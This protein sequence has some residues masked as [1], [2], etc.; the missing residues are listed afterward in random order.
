M[1]IG[2][3]ILQNNLIFKDFMRPLSEN[4]N[5]F[6]K[7]TDITKDL[8]SKGINDEKPSMFVNGLDQ[9]GSYKYTF[10]AIM[11]PEIVQ[12]ENLKKLRFRFFTEELINLGHDSEDVIHKKEFQVFVL[13]L[14][15][16]YEVDRITTISSDEDQTKIS[17]FPSV[18]KFHF[19]DRP[20]TERQRGK[21]QLLPINSVLSTDSNGRIDRVSSSTLEERNL[22]FI[23]RNI[24]ISNE[25]SSPVSHFPMPTS[26]LSMTQT[27]AGVFDIDAHFS[28]DIGSNHEKRPSTASSV[29]LNQVSFLEI[30]QKNQKNI[31]SRLEDKELID[32]V[33]QLKE[34]NNTFRPLILKTNQVRSVERLITIDFNIPRSV[35]GSGDFGVEITPIYADDENTEK[36]CARSFVNIENSK[37]SESFLSIPIV[38]P[39]I[40]ILANTPSRCILEIVRNDPCDTPIFLYRQSYNPDTNTFSKPSLVNEIQP[41]D[42]HIISDNKVNNYFPGK[43]VYKV[44]QKQSHLSNVTGCTSSVIVPGIKS[45]VL[46]NKQTYNTSTIICENRPESVL[47]RVSNISDNIRKI[48]L[49]RERLSSLGKPTSEKVFIPFRKNLN[50]VFLQ[51]D[52]DSINFRDTTTI[53]GQKYRYYLIMLDE[54]G[55]EFVSNEEEFLER[56]VPSLAKDSFNVSINGPNIENSSAIFEVKVAPTRLGINFLEKSLSEIG[57][58]ELLDRNS[59]SGVLSKD[60]VVFSVDEI[61][62]STGRRKFI[63]FTNA[64]KFTVPLYSDGATRSY[65]FNMCIVAPEA[66][67]PNVDIEI[68]KPGRAGDFKKKYRA[69]KFKSSL[70]TKVGAIPSSRRL[71]SFD[72]GGSI[73]LGKTGLS[74]TRT[75]KGQTNKNVISDIAAFKINDSLAI[76]WRLEKNNRNSVIHEEFMVDYFIVCCRLNGNL[77]T[78]GTVENLKDSGIYY[79]VDKNL[80]REVGNKEYFVIGI[81]NNVK[82]SITSG[83]ATHNRK[84]SIPEELVESSKS[85]LIGIN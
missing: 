81:C 33:L 83:K 65:Q 24:R 71:N 57:R 50:E 28:K 54:T 49:V 69:N 73:L 72:V 56:L 63:D 30:V 18:S 80:Y 62:H 26:K 84:F 60:F 20:N 17:I 42:S 29:T 47:V 37:L 70:L 45:G 68:S 1:S 40:K 35:V 34:T 46:K 31:R 36:E 43:V 76:S 12:D 78:L 6:F 32:F 38:P 13:N 2:I 55:K 61:N 23:K 3:P 58:S 67:V 15:Q 16:Q 5:K 19:F 41:G 25:L 82:N 11:D 64:G 22:D 39:T 48:R 14:E 52:M 27:R 66:I 77:L 75:V 85:E 59:R 7:L 10:N 44:S 51:P 4:D 53:S 9:F 21:S 8:S 79:F 74:I